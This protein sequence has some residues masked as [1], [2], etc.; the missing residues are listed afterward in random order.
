MSKSLHGTEQQSKAVAYKH[1]FQYDIGSD[2]QENP[3]Y[4]PVRHSHGLQ[5]PYR[6]Y[7]PKK[8]YQQTGNHVKSGNHSHQYQYENHVGVYQVQP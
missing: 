2:P 8:Q 5:Y 4:M 7:I 1:T 6:G 3:G